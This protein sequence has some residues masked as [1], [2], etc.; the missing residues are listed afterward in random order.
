MESRMTDISSF[1]SHYF[2]D[3]IDF[4][5]T[6]KYLNYNYGHLLNSSSTPSFLFLKVDIGNHPRTKN[7]SIAPYHHHHHHHHHNNEMAPHCSE[8]CDNCRGV[9]TGGSSIVR[10]TTWVSR[11]NRVGHSKWTRH[12]IRS[13]DGPWNIVPLVQRRKGVCVSLS[14][15]NSR[16][17]SVGTGYSPPRVHQ[18]RSWNTV[19][20]SS[21]QLCR[22]WIRVLVLHLQGGSFLRDL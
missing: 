14:G 11:R 22:Q 20:D 7:D 4:G 12:G 6:P 1:C 13:H 19:R 10:C 5:Y 8:G 9:T 2:A 21:S 3:Y 18:W 15:G 16:I 17:T